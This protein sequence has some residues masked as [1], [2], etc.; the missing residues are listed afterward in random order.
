MRASCK[1]T[2]G[3]VQES[4]RSPGMLVSSRN[5]RKPACHPRQPKVQTNPDV[6]CETDHLD[7]QSKSII[8]KRPARTAANR[9]GG[10]ASTDPLI[11]PTVKVSPV[12]IP[13]ANQVNLPPPLKASEDLPPV[14]PSRGPVP[15]PVIPTDGSAGVRGKFTL[16]T[17]MLKSPNGPTCVNV[18][19]VLKELI[20][21]DEFGGDV[22]AVIADE[23]SDSLLVK[24][25]AAGKKMV[26][27]QIQKLE[28][29]AAKRNNPIPSNTPIRGY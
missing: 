18:S 11:A 7:T 6:I 8:F 23:G 15:S 25:T 26:E 2:S 1:N 3:K 4:G 16:Y 19:K 29:A 28:A 5:E 9:L 24:A 14:Y 20:A 12:G 10:K 22:T 21:I 27:V 13:Y 17:I